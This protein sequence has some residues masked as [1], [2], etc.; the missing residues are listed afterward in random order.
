M[1]EGDGSGAA[2]SAAGGLYFWLLW[3]CSPLLHSSPS[4][5]PALDQANSLQENPFFPL[6]RR[7]R[8][9]RRRH[10]QDAQWA[11]CFHFAESLNQCLPSDT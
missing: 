5:Q 2:H 11:I 1:L 3:H 8:R 10:F 4:L 7:H 9:R 6:C